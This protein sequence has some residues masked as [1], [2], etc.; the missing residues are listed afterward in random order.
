ME[1][2]EVKRIARILPLPPVLAAATQGRTST[3]NNTNETASHG[4][5]QQLSG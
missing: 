2:V 1:G 3:T 4:G 5:G